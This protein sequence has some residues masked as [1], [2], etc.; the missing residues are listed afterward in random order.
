M[1][2]R[3]IDPVTRWLPPTAVAPDH[4]AAGDGVDERTRRDARFGTVRVQD[5]RE[6]TQGTR[7]W[8]QLKPETN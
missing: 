1:A 8:F 5:L 3:P 4:V 7:E 2:S 6:A